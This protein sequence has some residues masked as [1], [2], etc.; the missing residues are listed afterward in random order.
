MKYLTSR[1]MAVVV[2][3]AMQSCGG[4]GEGGRTTRTFELAHV[5][6]DQAQL[7]IEPYLEGGSVNIRR[8]ERPAALT[9]TAS[10]GRLDQIEELLRRLDQPAAKVRLRFQIIEADGFTTSDPAMADVEGALRELFR[11]RGYRLVGEAIINGEA[12]STMKQRML[13]RDE[14]PVEL[15]IEVPAVRRGSGGKAVEMRLSMDVQGRSA[16]STAVTIPDGQTVVLGSARPVPNVGTL[17]LVVRPE[18]E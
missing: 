13:V 18:I 6:P 3:L 2:A 7:L 16:L 17:I 10:A 12:N 9:I 15:T 1:G 11:F 14:V 5:E 4:T 8:T